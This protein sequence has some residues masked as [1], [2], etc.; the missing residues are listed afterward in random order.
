MYTLGNLISLPFSPI[1]HPL[2]PYLSL[3]SSPRIH[4]PVSISRR[5]GQYLSFFHAVNVKIF[6]VGEYRRK[7]FGASQNAEWFDMQNSEALRMREDV[8]NEALADMIQFFRQAAANCS[9]HSNSVGILDATN[10]TRLHRAGI[11]QEVQ[12]LSLSLTTW[13]FS[14]THLLDND[15][16]YTATLC[17]VMS[18]PHIYRYV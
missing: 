12:S 13:L 1:I 7:K 2:P 16:C 4:R 11:Q 8:N 10:S 17:L 15:F 3:T 9:V 6:N 18:S 5:L 14:L